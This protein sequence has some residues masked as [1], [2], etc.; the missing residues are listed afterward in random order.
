MMTDISIVGNID[1][2]RGH[3]AAGPASQDDLIAR[4][5]GSDYS[6]CCKEERGAGGDMARCRRARALG[7][8]LMEAVYAFHADCA[9]PQ[10]HVWP[11]GWLMVFAGAIGHSRRLQHFGVV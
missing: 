1:T 2:Q 8:L 11:R 5:S 3:D 7:G 10:A 9:P 4:I 6:R